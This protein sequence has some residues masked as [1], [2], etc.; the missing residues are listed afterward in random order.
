MAYMKTAADTTSAMIPATVF[1]DTH[2]SKNRRT[3]GIAAVYAQSPM[4]R[5]RFAATSCGYTLGAPR[6]C[7]VSSGC[8][9]DGVGGAS[10]TAVLGWP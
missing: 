7:W 3:A 5:R 9:G 4:T 8:D 1:T 6:V 10:A 2:N